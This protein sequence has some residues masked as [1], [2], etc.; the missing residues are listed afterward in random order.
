VVDSAH[1]LQS[2][3]AFI[4]PPPCAHELVQAEGCEQAR[5]TDW[6]TTGDN[7]LESFRWL[8]G[9]GF[10]DLFAHVQRFYSLMWRKP[11]MQAPSDA[12]Q[13]AA[14]IGIIVVAAIIYAARRTE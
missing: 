9:N 3:P 2:A 7:R 12:K 1:A 6:K 11:E 5:V 13:V 10:M 8:S 14:F 4:N